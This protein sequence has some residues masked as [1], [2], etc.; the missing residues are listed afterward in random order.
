MQ[1]LSRNSNLH[2]ASV[3]LV[4]GTL[5]WPAGFLLPA[6]AGR[7][8]LGSDDVGESRLADQKRR[9]M[10]RMLAGAT[11]L[12]PAASCVTGR[13]SKQPELRPHVDNVLTASS[14]PLIARPNER[15][16]AAT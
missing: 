11:G 16:A 12:E 7:R 6:S 4:I 9:T 13:R 15:A 10:E 1:V 2:S 14:E 5:D 8:Q 3:G